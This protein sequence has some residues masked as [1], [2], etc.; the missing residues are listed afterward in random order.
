MT[1][2]IADQA[3]MVSAIQ[4]GGIVTDAAAMVALI[5]VPS[6][7]VDVSDASVMVAGLQPGAIVTDASVMVAGLQPGT[8]VADVSALA[9]LFHVVPSVKVSDQASFIALFPNVTPPA[10]PIPPPLF[11][12]ITS[13]QEIIRAYPYV[14]F[15]NDDNITAFFDAY[16]I[17][18]QAYL[19]WFNAL[20]LPIYTQAP[21]SGPLLDWVA[22]SL[23]GIS[24][25][26]LPTSL[27]RP[28]EGPA[29]TFTANSLPVNGYRPGVAD[30]YNATSDDTFRRIITWAF[31]K[32]DG[33]TFNPR[34]LK[35]RINRFLS[36]LNGTNVPNDTTFD[37]AVAPTG[38]K[39][40]DIALASSVE[41]TI[42]K[43]AVESGVIELPLQ[44]QWT[45]SLI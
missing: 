32:G 17:Y 21:V 39:Q 34:W 11:T 6:T 40:W 22:Q 5:A 10:P 38:F 1:D 24:R 29:N 27:G 42:F 12:G 36:G 44:I 37:V 28:P 41:A 13:V 23:Y 8:I 16:N 30:N 14:D 4:P 31:Y 19:D 45:V 7:P 20:N 2:F 3:A 25:P 18:A 43:I 15:Q 33:M 26:A 35:R 9:A